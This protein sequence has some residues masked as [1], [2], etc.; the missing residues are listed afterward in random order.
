MELSQLYCVYFVASPAASPLMC[1]QEHQTIDAR[2]H[3]KC[4]TLEGREV[5]CVHLGRPVAT[6]NPPIV[7]ALT[8]AGRERKS[9]CRFGASVNFFASIVS[10]IRI[11]VAGAASHYGT[12]HGSQEHWRS[13]CALAVWRAVR[14]KAQTVLQC[15]WPSS[16]TFQ[17]NAVSASRITRNWGGLGHEQLRRPPCRGLRRCTSP[18]ERGSPPPGRRLGTCPT[19]ETLPWGTCDCTDHAAPQGPRMAARLQ[20]RILRLPESHVFAGFKGL[21]TPDCLLLGRSYCNLNEVSR[22]LAVSITFAHQRH[23]V[24]YRMVEYTGSQ[25]FVSHPVPAQTSS[26][27]CTGGGSAGATK[28]LVT[29][30]ATP[31]CRGFSSRSLSRYCN[32]R[33][34]HLTIRKMLL[35][36]CLCRNCSQLDGRR[37]QPRFQHQACT[38]SSIASL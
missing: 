3:V 18:P 27:R 36:I 31:S 9:A 29:T 28:W 16:C 13:G 8:A 23:P 20:A 21:S 19:A 17:A 37:T 22:Q 35:T 4:A 2:Q 14:M 32:R 26:N 1:R 30:A 6:R 5:L 15:R 38:G 12:V 11:L 10:S 7:T 34:Q 33:T 24:C 25:V